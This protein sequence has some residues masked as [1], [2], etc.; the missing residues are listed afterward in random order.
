VQHDVVMAGGPKFECVPEPNPLFSQF[1]SRAY[2]VSCE[3]NSAACIQLKDK[4]HPTDRAIIGPAQYTT[5][6]T[7]QDGKEQTVPDGAPS[8]VCI[9]R[10]PTSDLQTIGA[11]TL[12]G[13]VFATNQ[14][15]FV[16]YRGTAPSVQ[17]MQ[18]QWQIVGGFSPLL[19]NLSVIN[20]AN[21]SPQSL[22]P[23]P[24][25]GTIML[26]DGGDKGLVI[27]DL[28]SFSPYAIY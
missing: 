2:E 25:D 24:F 15:N 22:L 11:A 14:S 16:I 6:V 28:T 23:S 10:D 5:T 17:D 27:V 20:D 18:F 7:G 4:E 26:T 8:R 1:R 12:P 19:I 13:C 3:E 9:I 21:T